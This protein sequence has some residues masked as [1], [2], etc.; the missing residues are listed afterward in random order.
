M[1]QDSQ[2]KREIK[3]SKNTHVFLRNSPIGRHMDTPNLAWAAH[4]G[5]WMVRALWPGSPGGPL[6]PAVPLRPWPRHKPNTQCPL[7]SST[8]TCVRA[9]TPPNQ[10]SPPS[11]FPWVP[12]PACT[13]LEGRCLSPKTTLWAAD[14]RENK[15]VCFCCSVKFSG[16]RSHG[17]FLSQACLKQHL[18][19]EHHSFTVSFSHVTWPPSQGTDFCL[20]SQGLNSCKE[21]G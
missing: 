18:K 3:F 10:A 17:I 20:S 9:R 7:F 15:K 19:Y 5:Q 12:N 13:A 1:A 6:T 4:R 21:G 14:S 2:T 16:S 11:V 8:L